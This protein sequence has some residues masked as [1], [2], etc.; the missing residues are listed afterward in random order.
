MAHGYDLWAEFYDI[1]W[2]DAKED[3]N[4]YYEAVKNERQPVLELGCGTG[5]VTIPLACAGLKVVGL[6]ISSKMLEQARMKLAN[7]G[8][9]SGNIR[10]EEQDMRSFNLPE[11]FGA[12]IIPFRSF[13]HLLS[14]GDQ[15]K[16]LN[17]IHNHLKAQGKL[18]FNIFVP[19]LK[20]ISKGKHKEDKKIINVDL[21]RTLECE[22]D[23]KYDTFNQTIELTIGLT[24]KNSK[25]GKSSRQKVKLNSRYI[26]PFEMYHLLTKCNF[27][28]LNL[29]GDF[30]KTE[31]SNNS[32]EMIW[33]CE[34][35]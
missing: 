5:R 33:V 23:S 7:T 24:L 12:C 34:K 4:F 32:Q 22:F 26:F 29:Y 28:V 13:L 17:S 2:Q 15:E 20:W 11:R 16:C 19:N 30:N 18:I 31:F 3:I 27:K 35:T 1:V 14:L 9:I 6:D 8:K 25:T 21:D 10:F